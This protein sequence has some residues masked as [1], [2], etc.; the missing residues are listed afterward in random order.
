MTDR[1]VIALATAIYTVGFAV[2]L[3]YFGRSQRYPR[4]LMPALIGVGFAVHNVGIFWRGF[5]IGHCPLGNTFEVVQF[6]VWSLILCYLVIG[7]AFR[8]SLLGFFAA[9][10]AAGLSTL[11]LALPSWDTPYTLN[12]FG[13]DPRVEAHAAIAAFS[14]GVLGLLSLTAVMSWLQTW[15]LE[16]RPTA[17]LPRF[18]PSVF[19][20]ERI[21]LRLLV[22]AWL[23]L[24][25]G[26]VIGAVIGA[27]DWARVPLGKLSTTVLVWL[28]YGAV[29][30]L[31][32]RG[33]LVAKPF[34]GALVGLYAMALLV[35]WIVDHARLTPVG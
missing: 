2:G 22:L 25:L 24:T 26:L 12:V 13:N 27:E 28:A 4:W 3:A 10:M 33:R 34:A 21:N 14:Y 17:P 31:R 6:V 35:L 20:L 32:L 18:L 11:S 7:P 5:A 1:T 19:E 9:A 29:L 23:V 30:G 8:L 15:A 16:K